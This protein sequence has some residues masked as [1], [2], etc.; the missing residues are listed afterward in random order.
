MIRKML[1]RQ[2]TKF[3]SIRVRYI[4]TK[5]LY[6]NPKIKM[7][8]IKWIKEHWITILLWLLVVLVITLY[9]YLGDKYDPEFWKVRNITYG[10]SSYARSLEWLTYRHII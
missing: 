3:N 10:G 6:W 5:I 7:K 1:F 2:I 8:K 4:L 9:F